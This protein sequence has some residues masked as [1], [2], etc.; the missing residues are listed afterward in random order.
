[1]LVAAYAATLP[2]GVTY[3]RHFT[4]AGTTDLWVHDGEHSELIEAKS[5]SDHSYVRQALAQL[6]DY[7]PALP[8][9]PTAA[10][11]LF[12][13]RPSERGIELLHRYG[14]DCIYRTGPRSYRREPAPP[15]ARDRLM[16]FW[17]H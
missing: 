2:T 9:V 7:G 11:A 4:S 12:P 14:I 3:G 6:L 15:A 5:L 17:T 10:A 8:K 16:T 1:M 13:D